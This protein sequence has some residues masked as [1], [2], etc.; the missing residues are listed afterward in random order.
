[1]TQSSYVWFKVCAVL[2][3]YCPHRYCSSYCGM[4][5]V[6]FESKINVGL[7]CRQRGLSRGPAGQLPVHLNTIER[8]LGKLLLG[9]VIQPNRHFPCRDKHIYKT[10]QP[11]VPVCLITW[12][13][14]LDT[15][16]YSVE[17]STW[18]FRSGRVR[19]NPGGCSGGSNDYRLTVIGQF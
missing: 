5:T 15:K 11:R 3:H 13:H 12:R 17:G 8:R 14:W 18:Y 16:P 2:S 7:V 4:K 9:V 19:L 10:L 6:F 1:M